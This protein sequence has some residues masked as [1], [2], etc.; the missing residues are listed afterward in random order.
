[1]GELV[2][3]LGGA[4][5][6]KS[7]FALKE[8]EISKGR[9]AFIATAEALDEEMKARVEAHKRQRG[10]QWESFEE[11]VDVAGLID[12]IG[13]AYETI[14]I[15]CLTLWLSN[16][17]SRK[18]DI[19]SESARL[20]KAIKEAGGTVFAVSNEV[21]MGIVPEGPLG[22]AFRDEAGRLNQLVAGAADRVYLVTAG[23]PTRIK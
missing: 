4:R 13:A 7:A 21:G 1:M 20:L 22:R 6:G 16:L 17:F 14:L 9:K 11:P 19:P 5:S 2:F 23:I 18:A 12:R 15:D 3:V 8:C 10:R